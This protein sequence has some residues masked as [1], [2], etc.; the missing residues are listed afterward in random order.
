MLILCR[1][2][3]SIG[4]ENLGPPFFSQVMASIPPIPPDA[5]Y[6]REDVAYDEEKDFLGS[7]SYAEVYK[8]QLTTRGPSG[9]SEVQ[10]VA[11]K[12]LSQMRRKEK[13]VRDA[14]V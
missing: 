2:A 8:S 11:V 10:T 6:K 3:S 7:G 13:S 12:V 4:R 14:F 5:T 9:E 1:L